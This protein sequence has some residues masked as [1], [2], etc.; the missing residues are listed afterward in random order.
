MAKLHVRHMVGGR[1]RDVRHERLCRFEFPER[2]GALIQFLDALGG[3]WNIS[4]FHYRNHGA[5][6]GRVLAAFEVPDDE[7]SAFRAF[8][9]RSAIRTWPRPGTTRSIA[10]WN[11][12]ACRRAGSP[13]S[14]VPNGSWIAVPE[15]CTR[16]R[17]GAST[18]RRQDQRGFPS[19]CASGGAATAC[20]WAAGGASS[21]AT[22]TRST[23]S[24]SGC[25]AGASSSWNIRG[26]TQVAWTVESRDFGMW[27][28]HHRVS[29]V[30]APF[31][32]AKR[33]ARLQ[34]D[35]PVLYPG[36]VNDGVP[37]LEG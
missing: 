2:P 19:R 17:A 1:A 5:D 23:A 12:H 3:R 24:T 15:S 26:D 14:G 31:W 13:S 33:T 6:F 32:R 25:H 34:N 22:T 11:S 4:L 20:I 16:P 8:L 37:V 21:I 10:S 27:R 18:S 28:P 35:L 9:E 30:L 36:E 7:V 29:R